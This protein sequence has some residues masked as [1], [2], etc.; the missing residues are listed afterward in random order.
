MNRSNP[1][2]RAALACV[3][4]LGTVALALE[5]LG[6]QVE[7]ISKGARIEVRVGDRPLM[8]YVPDDGP[9]PYY[10][11]L[12]GATG[13]PITRA[14]PMTKVDGETIDHP[15]H[16]SMW[17]THGSINGVD[18]WTE[19]P[20]HGTIRETS[21]PV[22]YGGPEVG[23]IKTTD[24]WLGPDGKK[25]CEDERVLRIYVGQGPR[26]VI[27]FDVTLKASEGPLVF[28]DTKE[29]MFGLRVATSMDVAGKRGGKIVNAEGLVDQAAWGKASP[30][31]DYSGPVDGQTVGIAIL[32]HPDSFR[33]PTTWHVRDYGLFAANPFGWND[34]GKKESGRHTLPAG[35]SIRFRYRVIL[36]EGNAEAAK[37]P[38]A[39]ESYKAT[40][41]LK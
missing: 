1:G 7:F 34:F 17:F 22:V 10:Y 32:N 23:T 35:E 14:F 29:G 27:D 30:W 19:A 36:H 2:I 5:P 40:P 21:R 41:A 16:R 4:S 3:I 8:T 13:R 12:I 33:Y 6:K 9:K 24:D 11:P 31:V 15:H 25:V 37:L 20:G 39:F 18:F 26:R 28:G 38:E